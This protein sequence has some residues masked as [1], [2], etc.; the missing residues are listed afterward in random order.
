MIV[1]SVGGVAF[2]YGKK[3]ASWKPMIGG[4]V[5]FV[6]PFVVPKVVP[7]AIGA[8]LVVAALYVFRD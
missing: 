1:S 8:V 4:I 7:Q 3:Q 6:L 5:L 2:F